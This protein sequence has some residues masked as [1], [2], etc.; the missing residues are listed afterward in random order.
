[1]R[2]ELMTYNARANTIKS[3]IERNLK[4]AREAFANGITSLTIAAEWNLEKAVLYE[5]IER[6]VWP[7]VQEGFSEDEL[8]CYNAEYYTSDRILAGLKAKVDT[9]T[10]DIL[11]RDDYDQGSTSPVANFVHLNQF[12][13]KQRALAM[14]KRLI[15][16][17]EN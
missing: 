2:N 11:T 16:A 4:L 15:D 9:L 1:M 13:A 3:E 6:I 5:A 17:L 12:K 14:L 10:F 7:F 8:F